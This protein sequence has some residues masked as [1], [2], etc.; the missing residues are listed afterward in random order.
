MRVN[1]S[2]VSRDIS[3][4]RPHPASTAHSPSA[5]LFAGELQRSQAELAGSALKKELLALKDELDKAGARLEKEF[6]FENLGAFRNLLAKIIKK[7]TSNAYQVIQTGNSWGFQTGHI[8]QTIDRESEALFELVISKQKNRVEILKK[9]SS[10]KGL[11]V[12]LMS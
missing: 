10:I 8:V 4:D 11:V 3:P 2:T 12:D 1:D 7:V 6:S 9:I 5:P